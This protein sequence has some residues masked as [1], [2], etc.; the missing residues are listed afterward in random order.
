MGDASGYAATGYGVIERGTTQAEIVYW[1]S[2]SGNDLTVTR[3]ALRST[4]RAHNT[5]VSFTVLRAYDRV[6][7]A[8]QGYEVKHN[9]IDGAET[10]TAVGDSVTTI[11]VP[12]AK[13]G[14][15]TVRVRTVNTKGAF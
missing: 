6:Y 12:N 13:A 11:E 1:S 5:G 7:K 14:T 9:F 8:L 3:G 4:A 2:K 10:Q 15:Y